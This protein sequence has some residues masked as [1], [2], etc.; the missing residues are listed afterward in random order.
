MDELHIAHNGQMSTPAI[1]N[2]IRKINSKQGNCI[3]GIILTASHN[4]GGVDNDFGIKYNVRNGGPAMEEFTNKTYSISKQISEFKTTD[5]QFTT[6]INLQ[7][8]NTTYTFNNI[9][10]PWKPSFTVKIIDS[11]YDYVQLMR[12]S[13]NF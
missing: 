3:G 11:T 12:K 9:H 6:L 1:S 8:N 5:H 7:D 13:F 10:R 2:Y 4:P